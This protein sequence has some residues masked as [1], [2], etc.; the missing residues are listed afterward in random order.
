MCLGGHGNLL[1]Q[2]RSSRSSKMMKMIGLGMSGGGLEAA[3]TKLNGGK[4]DGG[5]DADEQ[6]VF[7]HRKVQLK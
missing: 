6:F 7:A 5:L 4:G 2:A 3:H 1:L